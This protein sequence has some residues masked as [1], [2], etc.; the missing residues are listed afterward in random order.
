MSQHQNVLR[1][2]NFFID[3]WSLNMAIFFLF[4]PKGHVEQK[5]VLLSFDNKLI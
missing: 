1:I 3:E 4:L 5:L 2:L